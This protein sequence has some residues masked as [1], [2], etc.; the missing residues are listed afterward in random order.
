MSI[1]VLDGG[2]GQE[3]VARCPEPPTG[4][5][6]T[7]YMMDHPDVVR[8]IHDDYFAAGA[9]VATTNSYPIHHDR[10]IGAGLDDRFAELHETACRIAVAAR[11]AHGSG[12]VA[13][14]IGPLGW[15]YIAELA[16]PAEEGAKLYAE[17]AAIHA[18]F[19]DVHILETIAGVEQVRAGLMGTA[20]SKHPTWVAISVDDDDGTR[21]RSGEPLTDA[22]P[23]LAEY[24]PAAVLLNCS[25]PEAISA[26]LPVI[27]QASIPF[28]AYANGFTSISDSFKEAGSAVT[29]LT[30]RTDLTPAA[31]ADFADR[32]IALGATI[33]GG[34]CE[35]GPAH[36]AEIARRHRQPVPA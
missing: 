29:K 22:L 8:A 20:G 4:L 33:I 31:Y 10:L 1:T 18:P 17:I 24:G 36:I 30:A 25:T 11:D 13:G 26:G 12:L 5:W 27:A 15:S 35:T 23:V 21:L 28:G 7:R 9:Q 32:W 14:S 6:A 34:C 3:L 16:P 19:V 2:M